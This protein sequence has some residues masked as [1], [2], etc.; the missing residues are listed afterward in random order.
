MKRIAASLLIFCSTICIAQKRSGPE[1]SIISITIEHKGQKKEINN[2]QFETWGGTTIPGGAG[3]AIILNYGASNAKKNEDS[4][5]WMFTIPKA[6]KGNYV[7]GA[8]DGNGPVTSLQ[9]TTSAFPNIPMF[10]CKSGS[11]TIEDCPAPGGFVKGNFDV[12]L[13]GG[14][15]SD[16]SLDE[17]EY[18]VT[19][20]FSIFRQ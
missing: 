4:F 1:A 12:I 11:V 8:R 6:E 5:N 20:T 3:S 19:G 10:M 18:R 16:G 17:S 7:I 15:T 9:F 2:K 13:T 14:V